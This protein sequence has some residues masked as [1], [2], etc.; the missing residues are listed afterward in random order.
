MMDP[1]IL[2]RGLAL[3]LEWGQHWLAPIHDRLGALYPSLSPEELGR[4]DAACRAAMR[5]GHEG[6][7]SAWREADRDQEKAF[8]L[9]RDAILARYPWISDDNMRRT[10]S[11]GMYYAW[12]DGEL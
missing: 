1:E 12:K 6:V 11:Q 8:A 9:W 2:D 3:A 4:Y 7:R 10:F 5:F